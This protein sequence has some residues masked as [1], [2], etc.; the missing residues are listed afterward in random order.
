[1]YNYFKNRGQI[2][3]S[4]EPGDLAFMKF[5]TG[6][7]KIEHIGLVVRATTT[8]VVTIEGNTSATGSQDNGGMVMQ[9][10]RNNSCIVA[11]ARPKYEGQ[12]KPQA[13]KDLDLV[14]KQVLSGK[15]G[16]GSTRKSNLKNAGFTDAEIAEIQRKVNNL[17]KK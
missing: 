2:V 10:T 6:P 16:N 8:G 9:K 5:S 15:Y 4:P 7:N 12:V 11:Y 3:K 17:L 1:M 13:T 14:A